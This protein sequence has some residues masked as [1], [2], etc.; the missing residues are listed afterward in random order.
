MAFHDNALA[1]P[2]SLI[3]IIS[4]CPLVGVPDGAAKA[5]ASA[6]AVIVYISLS[7]PVGVGVALLVI[8]PTREVMRLL[9]KVSL[10]AK[11]AIVPLVGKVKL[12][13]PLKVNPRPYF[14]VKVIVLAALLA[15]PVPPK[16]GPR[17]DDN[18]AAVPVI[19]DDVNASVPV[20]SGKVQVRAS[21]KFPVINC[22]APCAS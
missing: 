9:V 2:L 5:A 4:F 1:V 7:S 13:A 14:P 18:P 16:A 11:V 15:I 6:K 19:L 21:V 22:P 3:R 10:P 20:L 12:V 17:V 8:V